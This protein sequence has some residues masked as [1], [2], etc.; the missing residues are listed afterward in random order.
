M[1]GI[2][3]FRMVDH[4]VVLSIPFLQ[5][6][7]L[8]FSQHMQTQL[9]KLSVNNEVP[10]TPCFLLCTCSSSSMTPCVRQRSA[11]SQ[12]HRSAFWG[13]H[14]IFDRSPFTTAAE[15]LFTL[16]NCL[17]LSKIPLQ[18]AL[19]DLE[20]LII[21]SLFVLQMLH[22]LSAAQI[23][24]ISPGGFSS[25]LCLYSPSSTTLPGR[26]KISQLWSAEENMQ[27]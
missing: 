4:A 9:K 6:Q 17:V 14:L 7:R 2:A 12:K 10:P 13:L 8:L 1:L 26:K 25:Y 16:T 18:N 11:C 3:F 27:V 22:I 19:Q 5:M 15:L 23:F 21:C 24:F 20:L